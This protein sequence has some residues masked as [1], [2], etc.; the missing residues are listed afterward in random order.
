MKLWLLSGINTTVMKFIGL[1]VSNGIVA[2]TGGL[3]AQQMV[4]LMSTWVSVS[5]LSDF[6]LLSS[7]K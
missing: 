2:L 7:V 6:Q 4:L 5:S 1:M 3:I